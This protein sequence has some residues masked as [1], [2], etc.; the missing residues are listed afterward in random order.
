MS[1]TDESALPSAELAALVVDALMR[2]GLVSEEHVA[3]ALQIA[4]EE[5]EVRK[6]LGDYWCLRCPSRC[7]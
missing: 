6:A 1:R 3:R 4:E 2:A 5:I 7:G